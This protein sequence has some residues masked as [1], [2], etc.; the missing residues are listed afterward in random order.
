MS[1]K[2]SRSRIHNQQAAR[3]TWD[4]VFGK[5]A[6]QPKKKNRKGSSLSKSSD[7]TDSPASLSK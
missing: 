2:G 3:D 6:I 1:H 5:N 7:C 4:R